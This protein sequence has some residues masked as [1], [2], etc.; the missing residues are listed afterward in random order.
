MKLHYITVYTGS[1]WAVMILAHIV[2]SVFLV[3]YV[4]A[5]KEKTTN[6]S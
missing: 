2:T 6:T 5:R 1:S 3:S 4:L